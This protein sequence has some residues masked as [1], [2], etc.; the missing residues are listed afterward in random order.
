VIRQL[1][2][3]SV[4]L[5]AAG[6]VLGSLAG[7]WGVRIFETTLIPEDTPAYLTFA[8][9]YRVLA[10][11]AAI[12]IGTGM[13][14]GLAPALRLSKLDINAVLKDGGQGGGIGSRARHLSSLLVVTEM[15]LAFVLLVGAGLMI[16]SFLKM[17]RTPIG[18]RTDHLMSMDIMLRAKKYP[19]EASQ[20]SFH[21]QLR[22]R[23]EAVPGVEIR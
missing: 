9:D 5:S 3:E 22:T 7:V 20:I 12:T 11:L 4:L 1:L 15:A 18:A 14:F 23:L 19:T 8:M 21:Q 6:G 13:L 16:R 2:V 17:A 10:F